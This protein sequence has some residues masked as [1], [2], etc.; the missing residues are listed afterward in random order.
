MFFRVLLRS[1]TAIFQIHLI[2]AILQMIK[3]IFFIKY[4][5]TLFIFIDFLTAGVHCPLFNNAVVVQVCNVISRQLSS[6]QGL[7]LK[8]Y[9]K[10]VFL[11]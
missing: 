7:S 1:D 6:I 11:I 3:V 9:F 4:I 8:V 2:L 10:K 5:K